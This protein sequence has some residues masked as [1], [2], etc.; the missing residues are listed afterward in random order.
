[1]ASLIENARIIL[2]RVPSELCPGPATVQWESSLKMDDEVLIDQVREHS[3]LYDMTHSKYLDT[4]FK[5][6]IW[7]R[8]G[9]QIQLNGKCCY[10]FY[11]AQPTSI[12]VNSY[13]ASTKANN[14]IEKVDLQWKNIDP[15]FGTASIVKCLPFKMH[16][17]NFEMFQGVLRW[18]SA[19]PLSA[20][21]L[22]LWW[23]HQL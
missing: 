3:C 16:L 15:L 4:N 8:I 18:I 14:T 22:F 2:Q 17:G 10:S 6:F 7:R 1:M 11:N 12:T 20:D 19:F 23:E 21:A 13:S 5:S 9:E